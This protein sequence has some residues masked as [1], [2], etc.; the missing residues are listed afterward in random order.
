MRSVYELHAVAAR[1]MLDGVASQPET[2]PAHHDR[3]EAR[4][5]AHAQHRIDHGAAV[6][7]EVRG[8]IVVIGTAQPVQERDE[9]ARRV[10]LEPAVL[11]CFA[12]SKDDVIAFLRLRVQRE[13]FPPDDP[14]GRS[15]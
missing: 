5:V 8:A 3:E 2:G 10:A 4:P 7:A 9:R 1:I 15:P 14:A 11:A 13:R 6:D 12:L